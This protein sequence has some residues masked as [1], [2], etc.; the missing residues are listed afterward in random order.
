MVVSKKKKP[1]NN[2]HN[3][4]MRRNDDDEQKKQAKSKIKSDN[5][6]KKKKHKA[7]NQSL[8][9]WISSSSSQQQQRSSSQTASFSQ[10]SFRSKSLSTKRCKKLQSSFSSSTTKMQN[11]N[12][13]P[14]VNTK[15]W[16]DKHA[17]RSVEEWCVAPK[18]IEAARQFLSSHLDHVH[19]QQRQHS[20]KWTNLSSN[21]GIMQQM[22]QN[23][24]D[25]PSDYVAASPRTKLMVLVESPGIGKSTMIKAL[26]R[27]PSVEVLVWNDLQVDYNMHHPSSSSS[28][29]SNR[30]GDGAATFGGYLPYQSQLNSFE[31]FLNQGGV[32]KRSLDLGLTFPG[33]GDGDIGS[34]SDYGR[35]I[36][37]DEKERKEEFVGSLILIEEV[38]GVW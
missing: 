1:N 15:M 2:N 4:G 24:W 26:A 37:R 7:S 35:R 12:D 5:K 23:S 10:H 21:D 28:S 19:S 14:K 3:N 36:K 22:T 16:I 13:K 33:D 9:K 34:S 6:K 38:S 31:D 27:E 32:G 11:A 20:N 18:K 8:L 29:N 25:S 17:P 30:F